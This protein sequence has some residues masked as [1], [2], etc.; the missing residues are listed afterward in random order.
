VDDA[1][2]HLDD[3]HLRVTEAWQDPAAEAPS[4]PLSAGVLPVDGGRVTGRCSARP[5]EQNGA[6]LGVL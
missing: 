4:F 1:A 6:V 2:D 3:E 5:R